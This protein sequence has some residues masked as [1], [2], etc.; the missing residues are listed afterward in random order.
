MISCEVISDLMAIYA[1]GEASTET[2]RLVEEHLSRCSVCRQAFGKESKAERI[3]K[4]LETRERPANG[5]FFINRTRRLLFALGAGG[6]FMYASILAL[7][8]RVVMSGIARLPLPVLPGSDMLWLIVGASG[9]V[10]YTARLFWIGSKQEGTTEPRF[11]PQLTIVMLLFF[12]LS[13]A[14][15]HLL[16]AGSLWIALAGM[17]FLLV[18]LISTFSLLS[19]LPYFTMGTVLVFILI[20]CFLLSQAAVG[21]GK[22]LLDFALVPVEELGHPQ[23]GIPVE[24]IAPVDLKSLE[25]ELVS[26][27]ATEEVAG[28]MLKPG[29]R[30]VQSIYQDDRQ[31]VFLTIV[32][33]GD[34][35][36]ASQFY[37][38]W[39]KKVSTK[40]RLLH[41]DIMGQL[42]RSYNVAASR[43]YNAWKIENWVVILE[44][45]GPFTRAWPLVNAVREAVA[46]SFDQDK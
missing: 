17:T 46:R 21:A 15:Y 5:R 20:I 22:P 19:R 29:E 45:A 31:Q 36:E 9:F 25:L 10:F 3:L 24:K 42:F 16:V 14:A 18:A 7:F 39:K 13:L 34:K 26:R 38:A 33:M 12:I 11:F 4:E 23:E 30:A 43:A 1:S 6:L 44:V 8:E 32:R 27:K 35:H 2:R 28:I 37:N 41:V 40:L